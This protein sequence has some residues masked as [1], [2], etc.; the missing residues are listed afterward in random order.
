MKVHAEIGDDKYELELKREGGWIRAWIDGEPFD[1]EVSQPEPNVFLFKHQG[2]IIEAF[3]E[4][5]LGAGRSRSVWI[6]GNEYDVRIFDPK[7]LRGSET[8]SG[9]DEGRAEIRSAMPGKVVRV[10][11]ELGDEVEKGAGVIVVEAMKM[12]NELKTPKSGTVK[13]IKVA[14]GDTVSAGDVLATIE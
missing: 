13:S 14:E 3:V 4:P 9:Q 8:V 2:R 6:K 5:D 11:V 10:L 1:T 7:R 12:Q